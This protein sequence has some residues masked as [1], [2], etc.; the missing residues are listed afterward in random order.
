MHEGLNGS[1]IV[2]TMRPSMP[3]DPRDAV[4]RGDPWHGDGESYRPREAVGS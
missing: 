3:S 1:A 4:G 2:T